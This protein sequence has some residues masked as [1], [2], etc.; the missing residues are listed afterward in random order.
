VTRSFGDK[1][2]KTVDKNYVTCEPDLTEYQLRAEDRLLLLA[3]DGLWDVN[4]FLYIVY[5]F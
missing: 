1:E 3:T 2:F 4:L 5:M